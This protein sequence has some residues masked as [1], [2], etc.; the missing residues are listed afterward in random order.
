MRSVL[1]LLGVT[2]GVAAVILLV[3]VGHGSAAA[4]QAQIEGLG[5]NMLTIQAGGRTFGRQASTSSTF[6]FLTMKDVATLESK[7]NAPDI[8]SVTPVVTAQS[9]TAV[10]GSASETP[11]QMLGTTPSY[12]E[13]KKASVTEGTFITASDESKHARVA[14]IGATVATNLFG[15]ADPI[16]QTI[17][18]SGATFQVEGLLTSKGTNGIQDQDDIV[19]V[20]RDNGAG[21]ARRGKRAAQPDHRRG[22]VELDRQRRAGGRRSHFCCRRIKTRTAPP[23]STS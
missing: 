5:T 2:I 8:K 18:L 12:A 3:A 7:V 20:P 6:T 19:I 9:V 13:A 1:T 23:R 15:G 21:P 14:V 22:D 11:G 4:V 17:Q 16:G 10:H